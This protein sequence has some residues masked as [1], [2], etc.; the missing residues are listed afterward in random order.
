MT[1]LTDLQ[2]LDD[3]FN[4]R[5]F[6]I[7]DYQRGYSW[8]IEQLEDFWDD[9]ERL[10]DD[11][12][13]YTGLLTFKPL[14]DS[15]KI[16]NALTSDDMWKLGKGSN[17]KVLHVV[18]GQQRLTTAIILI[19]RLVAHF[20]N[21]NQN[22]IMGNIEL[23]RITEK[24]LYD[25]KKD[26]TKAV[27][28]IFGYE[29]SDPA[30][31]C[32][33]FEI[34]NCAG[35]PS[36][37]QQTE[38]YYT[39]NLKNAAKF[40]D[41][42]IADL[43]AKGNSAGVEDLYEKL[44]S[45]LK[46]NL[47]E[48]GDELDEYVSFE[49]MNN[50]GK[51]LSNLELLKNRLIY[52][53]T[54]FDDSYSEDER[55]S[56]RDEINRAWKEIYYWLGKQLN[57]R[58][59]SDD[60]FLRQHWIIHYKIP[61]KTNDEVMNFFMKEKFSPKKLIK[62]KTGT[63]VSGAVDYDEIKNYVTSLHDF[64]EFYY[65][66]YYPEDS[67]LPDEDK[68]LLD[69]LTPSSGRLRL[70]SFRPLTMVVLYRKDINAADRHNFFKA[71]ERLI[72]VHSLQKSTRSNFGEFSYTFAQTL[73]KNGSLLNVT[74]QLKNKIDATAA[75]KSFIEQVNDS[76]DKDQHGNFKGGYYRFKEF[77]RHVLYEYET[78]LAV[79]NGVKK[80][81]DV[82]ELFTSDWG[83]KISVEHIFPQ[84]PNAYWEK[85]FAGFNEERRYSLQN[86][87][88]NLLL[89]S[90]K[91]NSSLQ[92]ADYP[93]KTARYKN[94]SH[95][96]IEVAQNSQWTATEILAR[97]KKLVDFINERWQLALTNDQKKSLV[98]LDFVK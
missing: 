70:G 93:I 37:D 14:T 61:E 34:F 2:S 27:S 11:K 94:N 47:H 95:S 80:I 50:R 63:K 54:L 35:K 40:F 4:K 46:F 69:S 6:R 85:F 66:T 97:S 55:I 91:I 39:N 15:Q 87:L 88:G 1:E 44:V 77:L 68:H 32:L 13:H 78:A 21:Q 98:H 19:H 24:Y 8:E 67:N 29:A 31:D 16:S 83:D 48:I 26:A 71:L 22:L 92:N 42:K 38:N 25:T 41:K 20:K 84:T 64:A 36:H 73:Y 28:C 12:D 75:V 89:L 90:Q 76:F 10:E 33:R 9:L 43:Y 51:K 65:Y 3:I 57:S 56:L 58:H 52:L 62:S 18:D 53:T 72:F 81:L 96:A 82:K 5:L 17:F 74:A 45:H 59:I 7:P 79:K 49:T 60:D 23:D 30:Y 86:A